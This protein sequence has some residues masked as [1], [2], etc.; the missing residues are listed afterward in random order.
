MV[1]NT[2]PRAAPTPVFPRRT[3]MAAGLSALAAGG[4]VGLGVFGGQTRVQSGLFQFS[5]GVAFAA[6]QE[7]ALRAFLAPA[8]VDDRVTVVIS[9]H[10]G[11]AGDAT[12]NLAL[13]QDR[14]DAVQTI[15]VELG[16]TPDRLIVNAYGGAAPLPQDNDE[17]DRVYQA[18][19]ARVEVSLQ[20]RK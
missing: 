20:V 11:D 13:S 10:T 18:R 6:G 12:A 5:R 19:L 9:G 1:E 3:F 2:A 4:A 15:A 17:S 16:I 7:A 8:V 14:A